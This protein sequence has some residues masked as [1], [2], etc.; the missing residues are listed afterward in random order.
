[1]N[2]TDNEISSI[3][4]K[5]KSHLRNEKVMYHNTSDHIA[6]YKFYNNLYIDN[7]SSL[8]NLVYKNFEILPSKFIK[9]LNNVL[10]DALINC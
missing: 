8:K 1:M 3:T 4:L 2:T 6:M 5:N 7:E 9:Y 10:F